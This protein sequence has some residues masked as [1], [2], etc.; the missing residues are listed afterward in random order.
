[1]P[2]FEPAFFN[3]EPNL[4]RAS[5]VASVMLTSWS[6]RIRL[7]VTPLSTVALSLALLTHVW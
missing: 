7:P 1:M 3:A 4:T 5:N 6:L 2:V